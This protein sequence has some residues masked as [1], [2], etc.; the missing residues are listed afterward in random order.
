MKKLIVSGC[1]FT[2]D[3]FCWPTSLANKLDV[4]LVNVGMGSQGNDL[5]KKSIIA[6]IEKELLTNNPKDL[7]VGIM[8]TG[9]DRWGYRGEDIKEVKQV[10]WGDYYPG[11]IQ[12]PRSILNECIPNWYIINAGWKN[13]KSEIYYKNFHSEI[14]SIIETLE[15]ILFTQLYLNSKGISY[16]MSTYMDILGSKSSVDISTHIETSYIYKNIDFTKFLP[17]V[18]CYDYLSEHCPQGMPKD[19]GNHPLANGHTYFTEEIIFPYLV[20]NLNLE[21]TKK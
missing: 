18:S 8:W 13:K 11:Q 16:F 15:D 10:S 6:Q 9:T 21:V 1:S 7:L 19:G 2:F 5:I 4:P 20:K 12:N 17:V 3:D 14:G